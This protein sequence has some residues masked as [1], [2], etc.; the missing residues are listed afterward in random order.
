VTPEDWRARFD[1]VVA[2]RT[3]AAD[4]PLPRVQTI[5]DRG[6]DHALDAIADAW[7]SAAFDGPFYQSRP[8]DAF[9][10][11]VVF[12]RSRDGNTGVKDP[13]SLGGG[14]V[15]EHLIYEGL[16]RVAVD[17]VVVGAGTLCRNSFF[18]VWRTELIELRRARGLARHPAQVVLT[19]DGTP[20]P[21]DVLLFNVPDVPVFVVTSAPG[22]DRLS[23]AL[24]SRPWVHAILGPS[25]PEQFAQLHA[26]G[27]TRFCSIGG[28]RSASQLV[29]AGLVQDVYLTTTPLS[30]GEPGTPWYVGTRRLS[31]EP[32][33][34]KE[35]GCSDGV[36]RFEHFLAIQRSS[37][38]FA[39]TL[40]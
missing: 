25:L 17:A 12:V 37:S 4:T 32:V 5:V 20:C 21:D 40:R 39:P 29:D 19:V 7:S 33:V 24:E 9:S 22:R 14:V 13:S 6:R 15:D 1:A 26:R 35:W 8:G 30:A 34:V 18:S 38:G 27:M 36:A 10:M 31:L 11:G 2:R 16:S 28:R 23:T 3:A